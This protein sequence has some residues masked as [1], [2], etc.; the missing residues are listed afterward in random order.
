MFSGRWELGGCCT[1]A[2]IG[3]AIQVAVELVGD[4]I[5]LVEELVVVWG[6]VV[7]ENAEAESL[8]R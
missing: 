6:L 1:V 8:V 7:E 2:A 4:N 3:R 5:L